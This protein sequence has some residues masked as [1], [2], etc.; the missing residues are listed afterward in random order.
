MSSATLSPYKNN[1]S[2]IV[3]SL[4][5]ESPTGVTYLVSGRS[6]S[7]PMTLTIS[8][9]LTAPG[10]AGNDEISVLVKR[11]DQNTTTLKLSTTYAKVV[12]SVPKDQSVAT[13]TIQKEVCAVI[14]S[15]FNESTAMEAT[16]AF[17]TA[18]IE[19]RNP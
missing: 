16:N 10:A 4:A 3:F 17:L 12:I 5:S 14:A 8:R 13:P 15:L 1:T 6:I 9:K 11:I 18:L 7:Q 19:G 2:T